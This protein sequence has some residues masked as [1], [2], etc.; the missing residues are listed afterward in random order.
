M[1]RNPESPLPISARMSPEERAE[2]ARALETGWRE[3]LGPE[4]F[5]AYQRRRKAPAWLAELPQLPTR[6]PDGSLP[7]LG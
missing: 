3:F 6:N 2:F 4:R 1:I 7:A 5:E